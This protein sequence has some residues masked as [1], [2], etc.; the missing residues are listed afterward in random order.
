MIRQ[1]SS[2]LCW[3]TVWGLLHPSAAD[4]ERRRGQIVP[5]WHSWHCC[6]L[7][8]SQWH[9]QCY[10][11][12]GNPSQSASN[13]NASLQISQPCSCS[14]IR[15]LCQAVLKAR[16]EMWGWCAHF[17]S[18]HLPGG[19]GALLQSSA[20]ATPEAFKIIT[21]TVCVWGSLNASLQPCLREKKQ[22]EE[23]DATSNLSLSVNP[24]PVKSPSESLWNL[25]N[26][27]VTGYLW[28][29]LLKKPKGL[30]FQ[31]FV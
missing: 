24:Q 1:K 20:W 28:T 30:F 19:T 31:E 3:S 29:V 16:G 23:K 18:W 8:G 6:L 15:C 22:K 21:T 4:G 13:I 25:W 26:L 2:S 27:Q 12:N 11:C 7:P 14:G 10:H 17:P 9:S 5:V